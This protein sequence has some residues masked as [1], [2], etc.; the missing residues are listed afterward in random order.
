MRIAEDLRKKIIFYAEEGYSQI[1]IAKMINCHQSSISR[2]INKYINRGDTSDKPRSGRPEKTT[3]AERRL[4]CRASRKNPFMSSVELKCEFEISNN[5]STRTIRRILLNNKLFSRRAALKPNISLVNKKKRLKFAKDYKSF[6]IKNWQNVIFSDECQ[7]QRNTWIRKLVRRPMG[8]RFF[9]KYV[10]KTVKYSTFSVLVWGAIKGDG[11]SIIL[12]CPRTL[13]SEK[14][15]AVLDEGLPSIYKY[16]NIFMQDNAS[17]HISQ[18]TSDFL[19]SHN[20]LLLS[21]WPPQ[22][23]DINIIENLWPILKRNVAKHN[24]TS[25][26]ALWNNILYEWHQIPIHTIEALYRSLP[27]RLALVRRSYGLHT[28]Y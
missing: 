11:S 12:R 9:N 14:Y 26:E 2:I 3:P 19:D 22:S 5:I 10:T 20:I 7:F 25:Q 1:S 23:P 18:R 13:N 28:K 15:I 16:D 17:C 21:D 4:I 24:S 6:T 8:K 27:E